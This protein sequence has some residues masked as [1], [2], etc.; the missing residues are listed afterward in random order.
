MSSP[1]I[2]K[3]FFT[4]F[5]ATEG[6]VQKPPFHSKC[7]YTEG[8]VKCGE[9]T[10]PCC[11]FCRKHIL[12]D[13]KQILFKACG[14][15]KSGVTCQEPLANIFEDATCFLH[16]ELPPQK[17]FTKKK[18]ESESDDDEGETSGFEMKREPEHYFEGQVFEGD[19]MEVVEEVV[20]TTYDDS[21]NVTIRH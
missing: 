5:Q 7:S 1:K 10:L 15:E 19:G 18:Y 14:V 11:K 16:V 2:Y 13:K 9:R 20:T 6:L 17:V 21:E 3:S 8:G 4:Y 12:E